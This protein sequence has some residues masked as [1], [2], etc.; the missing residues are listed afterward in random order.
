MVPPD[1]KT[2][3]ADGEDEAEV[4]E[5][6]PKGLALAPLLVVFEGVSDSPTKSSTSLSSLSR[7]GVSMRARLPPD[8]RPLASSPPF[9]APLPTPFPF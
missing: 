1:P 2:N 4:D 8:L 5:P 6:K 3:G 9:L 7:S